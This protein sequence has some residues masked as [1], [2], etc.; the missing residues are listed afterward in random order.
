MN[1][2][3]AQLQTFKANMAANA[4][5]V[6][7]GG[8]ATPI[9]S[10]TTPSVQTTVAAA[11]VAAF[12]NQTASPSFTVWTG[13]TSTNIVG[14]AIKMSDVGNLTTA[15]STRLSTSFQIRPNGFDSSNQDDRALFGSLFSVSGAS[16][17]RANLLAAWQRL[18]TFFEK[19]FATGTGTAVNGD[20]NSDGSVSGTGSPATLVLNGQIGGQD[21]LN[22]WAS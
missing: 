19:I 17:T 12:Y 5:T 22:A 21:V 10:L 6:L 9:N 8:V 18:A 7:I 16:G 2:T 20:L 15:N 14:M 3:T 13:L 1:M 4:N 11:A